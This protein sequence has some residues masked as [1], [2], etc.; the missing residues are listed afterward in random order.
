MLLNQIIISM[1]Y[2]RKLFHLKKFEADSEYNYLNRS[3]PGYLNIF[4]KWK[5]MTIWEKTQNLEKAKLKFYEVIKSL[6]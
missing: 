5:S 3:F 4:S 6:L 2:G 1:A